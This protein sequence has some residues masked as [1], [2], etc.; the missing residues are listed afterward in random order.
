[1]SAV[2]AN[3][4]CK[5]GQVAKVK[6]GNWPNGLNKGRQFAMCGMSWKSCDFFKWL[7]IT[8][9]TAT[10]E[11]GGQP[12]RSGTP[13]PLCECHVRASLRT[14]DWSNG[15]NKGRKFFMCG[16]TPKVCRFFQWAEQD[17]VQ[18]VSSHPEEE[19]VQNAYRSITKV[20]E[21]DMLLKLA[22]ANSIETWREEQMGRARDEVEAT[23]ATQQQMQTTSIMEEEEDRE[24]AGSPSGGASR[25]QWA[26]PAAAVVLV[27]LLAMGLVV[28]IG[29]QQKSSGAVE[30]EEAGGGDE[31]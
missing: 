16:T 9:A 21:D 5:C 20:G 11:P 13:V 6:T 25:C 23:D 12:V 14:G 24:K 29:S 22:L 10:P 26:L 30:Q 18:T 4:L 27:V 3:Q 2:M 7:D 19:M 17:P 8:D 28:W 31:L 15:K 1:M